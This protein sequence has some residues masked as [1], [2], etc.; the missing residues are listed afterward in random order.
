M[1]TKYKIIS[2]FVLMILLLAG[3]GV[4][5]FTS[6]EKS[7]DMFVEYRRLARF[8][9]GVSDMQASINEAATYT[10]SYLYLRDENEMKTATAAVDRFVNL[11]QGIEAEVTR[12]ESKRALD[13]LQALA[14]KYKQGQQTILE[15]LR[16][17]QYQYTDVI[18]PAGTTVSDS[19]D[20]LNG[21]AVAADNIRI[22]GAISDSRGHYA[23]FLS[24]LGRYA[25][26]YTQDIGD[27]L[28]VR[29]VPLMD[30]LEV[31][32]PLIQ[33]P[34]GRELFDQLTVNLKTLNSAVD[35][36]RQSAD[37]VRANVEILDQIDKEVAA[38]LA[39]LNTSVDEQMRS[40]GTETLNSNENAQN[41]MM[42]ASAVGILIG[43]AFAL[44]II[45][46]IVRVLTEMSTF[47]ASVA[48]GDFS[49]Q[50]KNR[51]RG[52][53]GSTLSAMKE[54][55][56]VL[57]QVIGSGQ[58][59]A[60]NIRSGRLR[61]R[62][63]AK[64]FSGAYGDLATAVNSVGDA[65]TAILDA[66][67][68]PMMSADKK[69]VIG[70]FNTAGQAA[71]GGNPVDVPCNIVDE[72]SA[73]AFGVRAMES[74]AVATGEIVTGAPGEETYAAVTGV[75]L[76]DLNGNPAAFIEIRNDLTE[77]RTQQ[78]IMLNVAEQA[79]EISNRVA[80]ASE[81]L[82]A[83]VEQVSRGA[84]MQRERVESTA[85][86]MAEMNATVLEVARSAGQ[87]SDQ[88][89][90]TRQKA[91]GGA[92]LVTQVT[93]AINAV[94]EVGQTLHTNMAELG[95]QAESIGS[96]MNVISDI[97]DQTNLLALNAAIEAAR[98]GEAGRGFAVVADE[99]RKLAEKTMAA[100]QEVGSNITAIQQS[101]R[102]NIEEVGRAV[103]A[104][105]D[106]TGLANSSGEAL[107][108]IVSLA[109]SNSAVVASIATAAEEQSATSEEINR[110]IEEINQIV[111]ETTE[112]MVQ[113]S[114]AVQD[115]SRMAQE[116]YRVMEGLK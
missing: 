99:V 68:L 14:P 11:S 113:S 16:N 79:S 24:T 112:G 59:L 23:L 70:F 96:V 67:P 109:S 66:V 106:A 83:Q 2:G 115:L 76:K 88:S 78:K 10:Y 17:L 62:L 5:G 72:T 95:K 91:E 44:F 108:E 94:N 28:A 71:V 84:E 73:G 13:A 8:N 105:S 21:A 92:D 74:N 1:T 33:T 60:N 107:S 26:A 43:I 100:T 80:A 40:M 31:I 30:S 77:I 116:L 27:R 75:P 39:Q 42:A 36:M 52:E 3:V 46:G 35:S 29:L 15:S 32:E 53:I 54:I 48:R 98:A 69:R 89:D 87:A 114:A 110:A 58:E 49:F 34:R 9:V 90:G 93:R 37:S 20:A 57:S 104:V 18:T 47:A 55:P 102:I 45:V 111:G 6:V 65:Y 50:V 4:L 61:D 103:A 12:E 97:A 64:D 25:E 38:T 81:E 22:A 101:A 51:E 7:S 82:A 41:M 85:S 19:L 63:Q 56:A 86:A